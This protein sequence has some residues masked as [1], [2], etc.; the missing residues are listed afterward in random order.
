MVKTIGFSGPAPAFMILWRFKG[1]GQAKTMCYSSSEVDEQIS[2]H[3]S[4]YA[5]YEVIRNAE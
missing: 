5:G 4:K 1:G 2:L 3:A